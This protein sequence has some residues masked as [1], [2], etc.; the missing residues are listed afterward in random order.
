MAQPEMAARF[1]DYCKNHSNDLSDNMKQLWDWT[2]TEFEDSDKMSSPLQGATMQ[3][4]AELLSAKRS[5]FKTP[6]K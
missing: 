5:W 3:F 4:F 1:T 6:T 2:V